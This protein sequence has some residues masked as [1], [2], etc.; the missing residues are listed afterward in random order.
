MARSWHGEIQLEPK[1]YV[2]GYC[3]VTVG[4]NKGTASSEQGQPQTRIY[5]CSNCGQPTYFDDMLPQF[6]GVKFGNN[7]GHLP[8]EIEQ[9]YGEARGSMSAQAYTPAVLACRKI[10]M[11]VAVNVGAKAGE[12]FI[13]YVQFLS[14]KGYIPPNGKHWVDHI[15]TKSN[16]A[17]HEMSREEAERLITFVEMMLKFIYELPSVVPAGT[18]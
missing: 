12:S 6:P 1:T 5:F 3:S 17:N 13:V 4:P 16:E 2:C 8:R 10:L 15:R 18:P 14:D 7:V 11:N 9:L